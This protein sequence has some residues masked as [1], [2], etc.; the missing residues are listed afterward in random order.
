MSSEMTSP[1]PFLTA[2]ITIY[3]TAA[4]LIVLYR[5]FI[6]IVRWRIEQESETEIKYSEPFENKNTVNFSI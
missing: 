6:S 5:H 2:N 3:L 1:A 4:I